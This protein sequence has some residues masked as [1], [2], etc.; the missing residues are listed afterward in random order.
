MPVLLLGDQRY[1]ANR[2]LWPQ[3]LACLLLVSVF[4]IAGTRVNA[5]L[6][7]RG[8][9]LIT[10]NSGFTTANGVTGGSGTVAD[11]YIISDW[12]ISS[13]G[14]SQVCVDIE[15][16]TAYFII[17]NLQVTCLYQSSIAM[18]LRGVSNGKVLSSS[19]YGIG[20]NVEI[21]SS[22]SI[23]LSNNVLPDTVGFGLVLASVTNSTVSGNQVGPAAGGDS[24]SIT[25]SR[26]DVFSG[27]TIFPGGCGAQTCT[28]SGAAL[29]IGYSSLITVSDNQISNNASPCVVL[30]DWSTSLQILNNSVSGGDTSCG[31]GLGHTNSTVISENR[32]KGPGG[33]WV[34]ENVGI[35]IYNSKNDLVSGNNVTLE[36]QGIL[37]SGDTGISVF[38]NNLISNSAQASD[39]STGDQWDNGFPSGGNYWSDYT[40][41]DPDNDG[42]GDTP[43]VF[44][45]SQDSYPLMKPFVASPDPGPSVGGAVV[46]VDK[47]ALLAPFVLLALPIAAGTVLIALYSRRIKTSKG[48][49]REQPIAS[50]FDSR[51]S[52]ASTRLCEI[53][54]EVAFFG[55]VTMI[56]GVSLCAGRS[57]FD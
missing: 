19:L 54:C 26:M 18:E 49:M 27:N 39:D 44:N 6:T 38:H 56:M 9:I 52:C 22:T 23:N 12:S 16:T 4:L 33:Q 17:Q 29:E 7:S 10:S 1:L 14:P 25:N 53:F 13:S 45:Y 5:S 37:L 3:L 48:K 55:R 32:V 15:S 46:P 11:P 31:I 36:R 24:V 47:L 43:Y 50:V 21:D 51:K 8:P 34:F 40:G 35:S 20:E 30:V 57:R 41:S 28:S 42:I 2:R